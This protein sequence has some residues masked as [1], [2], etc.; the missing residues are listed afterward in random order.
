MR[1]CYRHSVCHYLPHRFSQK[2]R[3][4][5]DVADPV[6]QA[7]SLNVLHTLTVVF[8]LEYDLAFEG[9]VKFHEQI[10]QSA[11]AVS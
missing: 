4:L 9:L 2:Y 3:L 7:L 5:P 6:S 11:L 10:E 8:V 1:D